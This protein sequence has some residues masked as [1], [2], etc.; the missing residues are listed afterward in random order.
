MGIGATMTE[1]T[2][3][4]L[5]TNRIEWVINGN[6]AEAVTVHH[7]RKA[8]ARG[9]RANGTQSDATGAAYEL[10]DRSTCVVEIRIKRV[11]QVFFIK[12]M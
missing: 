7:K 1:A 10:F 2:E 11:W 5:P 6:L 9:A 8:I 4:L 12:N 3:A